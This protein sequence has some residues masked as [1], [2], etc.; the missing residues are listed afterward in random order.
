M[1]KISRRQFLQVSALAGASA[2][3]AACGKPTAAPTTAPA[4]VKPEEPKA[5]QPTA[6][7]VA[8]QKWPR[9]VKRDRTLVYAF[10]DVEDAAAGIGNFY[11]N[12]W[13]Q[14][15]GSA[16]LEFPFYYCALTTRPIPGLPRATSITR[17]PPK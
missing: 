15:A 2:V 10:G 11:A 6:V 9:D 13:H 12:N 3:L 8:E 1:K 14:R 16:M 4:T 7:P 17:M 5:V